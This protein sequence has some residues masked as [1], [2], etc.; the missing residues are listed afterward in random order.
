M[1]STSSKLG[2]L[3]L[4]FFL[5]GCAYI[6]SLDENLPHQI[7]VWIENKDYGKALDTLYYIQPDNDNYL[8]L[9]RQKERIINMA[10]AFETEIIN[11]G[12]EQLSKKNWHQAYEV[13]EYGLGKLPD[14]RAI[15]KARGEFLASR[16]AY[17]KQLKLKLLQNKTKWLISDIDTRKEIARVIP[18][19]Y[20][21]HWLLQ[22]HNLDIDSTSK[23]LIE[24]VNDSIDTHELDVARQCLNI[25]QQ[26]NPSPVMQQG[27]L[28]AGQRLE[29]E[30]EVRSRKISPVGKKILR[31]AKLYV[32]R[33][34]IH[35]AHQ[36]MQALPEQDKKNGQILTFREELDELTDDYVDKSIVEGRKLYSA[37]KVQEAYLLWKSLKPIAPDNDR[38]QTLISRAE[39]ILIKLH[40]I[41]SSQE[42]VTPPGQ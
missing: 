1:T 23:T 10:S 14:S 3:A 21:A 17:L 32:A 4:Y 37:G 33:G 39:K 7:D 18:K 12:K 25:A 9:M 20:S 8:H 27:I 15:Q 29:Q 26:L 30:I 6:H 19:N 22:D 42:V 36:E 40:K 34:D 2:T 5:G 28:E 38:L 24:C 41:G 11:Q 13:Y 35:S 31:T 16:A